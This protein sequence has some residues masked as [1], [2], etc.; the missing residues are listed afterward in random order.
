[1]NVHRPGDLL[2]SLSREESELVRKIL[3]RTLRG[4]EITLTDRDRDELS[5]LLGVWPMLREEE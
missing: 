2:V 5:L 3:Y 1:M 4:F